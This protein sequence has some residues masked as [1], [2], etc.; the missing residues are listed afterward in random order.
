M[1]S[2]RNASDRHK[3]QKRVDTEFLRKKPKARKE[4]RIKV[5]V[6]KVSKINVAEQTFTVQLLLEAS[7]QGDDIMEAGKSWVWDD[8]NDSAEAMKLQSRGV[9]RLNLKDDTDAQGK[10]TRDFWAPRLK[11][12]NRNEVHAEECWYAI[13]PDAKDPSKVPPVVCFRWELNA[14]FNEL[15]ELQWFPLDSQPLQM[16]LTSGWEANLSPHVFLV[17]NMSGNYKSICNIHT[18]M[19]RNE[20]ELLPHVRFEETLT[21]AEESAQHAQYSVLTIAVDVVRQPRFWVINLGLPLALLT[22]CTIVSFAVP[23]GDIADRCSI[24]LTL[25]LA[26]IA[27][28][29][30]VSQY[31]PVLAYET[32]FDRYVLLCFVI[33]W[34]IVI[35]QCYTSFRLHDEPTFR[36]VHNVTTSRGETETRETEVPTIPII[37]FA[38]WYGIHLCALLAMFGYRKW[39][40][41]QSRKKSSYNEELAEK[42]LWIGPLKEGAFSREDELATLL[43]KYAIKPATDNVPTA[44]TDHARHTSSIKAPHVLVWNKSMAEEAMRDAK[45]EL[46]YEINSTFAVA[47]YDDKE[48]AK[49]VR[50]ALKNA[51]HNAPEGVT[52]M[53]EPIKCESLEVS[54]VLFTQDARGHSRGQSKS[55]KVHA[56]P[57]SA[58]GVSA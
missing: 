10:V 49:L 50:D 11:F 22:G 18:F 57:E 40:I 44:P 31:L 56:E 25:L 8:S 46:P 34:F 14:E 20:Y 26:Q 24:T 4:V 54:W 23:V 9:L 13:Y 47:L 37:L 45:W 43:Q 32:L 42:A 15:M 38:V 2:R 33:T 28:K 17:K 12:R 27:Y 48:H 39:S 29:Y 58:S 30:I 55:K 16:Q 41:Y 6:K 52:F 36:V 3:E 1:K 21:S 35:V 51:L 7:W 5:D 53:D 19:L